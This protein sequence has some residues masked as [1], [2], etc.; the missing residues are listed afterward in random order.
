MA[1]DPVCGMT[2]EPD[3]AAGQAD[4]QGTTYYFC[5]E[6]CRKAFQED[7]ERYLTGGSQP[8]GPESGGHSGHAG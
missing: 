5:A 1:T 8:S 3:Q 6:G 7:P 4:Y 2:V